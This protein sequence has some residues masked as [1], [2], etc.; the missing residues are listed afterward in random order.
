MPPTSPSDASAAQPKSTAYEGTYSGELHTASGTGT[1]V[2]AV[3][4]QVTNGRG[5]GT[6][7]VP[8]C[9][10][11]QFSLA[12]QPAGKVSGEG[13]FNCWSGHS[14]G[15]NFTGPFKISGAH[16]GKS[17]RLSFFSERGARID[18]VLTPS[19]Q[20]PPAPA[21]ASPSGA[22]DGTYTATTG[23]GSGGSAGGSHVTLTLTV[24][25]GRGL[26]AT[27]KAGCDQAPI[28]I[29][30][31]PAGEISGQGDLNCPLWMPP[32]SWALGP[33]TITGRARDGKATL[34]L[35]TKRGDFSMTLDRSGGGA[36]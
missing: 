26:L 27:R 21:T 19:A 6:L 12:V 23:A 35:S 9:S 1:N 32:N 34:T 7:T 31:S 22:F 10:P 33:A 36:R 17:L 15:L 13:Y 4:L 5:A 3:L 24:T 14:S 29:A 28:A 25:N 16:E 30:I 11:S 18:T 8:G 2:I 20:A